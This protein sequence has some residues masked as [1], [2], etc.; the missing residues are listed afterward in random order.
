MEKNVRDIMNERYY[1][2][3]DE[4][5]REQIQRMIEEGAPAAQPLVTREQLAEMKERIA[6]AREAH[7]HLSRKAPK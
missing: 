4:H 5:T 1:S 6:R 3:D 7:A 2:R